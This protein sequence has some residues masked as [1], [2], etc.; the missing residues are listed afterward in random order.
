MLPSP[1][2]WTSRN[3]KIYP[4]CCYGKIYLKFDVYDLDLSGVYSN[5][6][7]MRVMRNTS[8]KSIIVIEDIDC[9]KEVNFMPPTPEDLGYDETQDLGYAATHGLGYTGIVAPKKE[10]IIVFTTNHKDKV[11]PALLRPGRMDMHIHLSF[12]KANTFRILASNYLDIEEHH[13]PLFEQIEELLEKVDD[14]DVA[15]KA[16]LK[17]LQEIDIS[18]EK[19]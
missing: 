15:L 6:Y 14:A 7:L 11:D 5:S 9:N 2:A 13:Q 10:R 4:S 12:L 3:R 18:G 17:F 1:I 16:L 19:N 8:N